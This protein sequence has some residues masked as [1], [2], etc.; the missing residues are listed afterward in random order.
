MAKV[1]LDF[2]PSRYS[3]C[4]SWQKSALNH[5][6]TRTQTRDEQVRPRGLTTTFKEY[7]TELY[8]SDRDLKYV[9]GGQDHT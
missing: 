3:G 5:S 2:A 4:C 7:V 1:G 8:G 9:G 6:A